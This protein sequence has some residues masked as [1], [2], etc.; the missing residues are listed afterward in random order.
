MV[1][2]TTGY[3][4]LPC[5]FCGSD[6]LFFNE[7]IQNGRLN[8]LGKVQKRA[9]IDIN[10][11]CSGCGTEGPAQGYFGDQLQVN[12]QLLRDQRA[13]AALAWNTRDT[14]AKAITGVIQAIA[15]KAIKQI[16]EQ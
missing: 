2:E 7:A 11:S 16:N 6:E 5:P 4:L 8:K 15:E 13:S 10:V 1:G 3:K 9:T 12:E 14:T